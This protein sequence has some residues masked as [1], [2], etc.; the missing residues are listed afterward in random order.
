M[1]DLLCPSKK[2]RLKANSKRWID[3]E[4]ISAISRRDKLYKKYKK[5]GLETDKDHFLS[6]KIALQ[7]AISKKKKSFFQEKIEK[8]ANKMA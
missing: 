8:N 5:S 4:T 1:T 3:S 2:L 7:K 6:A